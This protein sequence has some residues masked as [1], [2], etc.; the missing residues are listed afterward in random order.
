MVSLQGN[1]SAA[2]EQSWS[3]I[4]RIVSYPLLNGSFV[5]K[6]IVIVPKG[7]SGCSAEIGD[8]GGFSP[9][10]LG[11]LLWQVAHP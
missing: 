9:V 4:V 3:V 10:V 5:I 2:F 8:G 7:T 6:S 1:S 11:L